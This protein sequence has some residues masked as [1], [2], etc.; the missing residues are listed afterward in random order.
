MKIFDKNKLDKIKDRHLRY[1]IVYYF[2]FILM[3]LLVLKLFQLTI[4]NGD[5]YRNKSDNNRLKD[6]KVTAPR[7][8]IY[9]RNG[10]LLAGVKSTPAVQILKDEFN[11]LDTEKRVNSIN[12]LIKYLSNDGSTWDS[13]DYFIGYNY[14]VY[15]SNTDY[16]TENKSPKEKILDII[17]EN[18][19]IGDILKLR[20]EKNSTSDFSY[21]IIKN[22]IRDLQFK[23]IYIP[24]DFFYVNSGDIKFSEGKDYDEYAKDKN[25]SKGIYSHITDL[26]KE[27]KSIIRKILEQ[28]LARKLIYDELKSKNLLGNIEM[29]PIADKNLYDYLVI[30]SQLNK[31]NSKV[32]LETSTEDDFYNM[33][34]KFTL[35]KLLKYVHIDK[36]T[37][38]K[39]IPA[40]ILI[41]KLKSK[42]ISL[43]IDYSV[44]SDENEKEIVDFSY[45]KDEDSNIDALNYLINLADENNVLREF[46]LSE[47]IAKIAQIVN[48]KENKILKISITKNKKSF[49]FEYIFE[50]ERRE[51][52]QRYNLEPTY[53]AAEL[54]S[55]LKK[56]YD[57]ENLDDYNSYN[58]LKILRM[59]ELQGDK[60]YLP[61]N[62]TYGISDTCI[63]NIKEHFV[64]NHGISVSMEPIRYYPNG[65]IGAHILGYIGK[66]S[67]KEEIEKYNSD[68]GYS[69]D[70]FIGKTGVEESQE[71]SLKGKDGF[72][73]VMVDNR[74]N[75][76]ETITENQ[77][78]PG[79]NVYLSLDLNLQKMAEESLK[80]TID[81]IR[82]HSEYESKWGKY[83]PAE[84]YSN[85]NSGAVVVLDVKTGKV[86]ALASYP[87]YDPNLF[88]T[89]ISNSDWISLS[90]EDDRDYLAPKPLYNNAIQSIS[91]PGST[92]KLVSSLAALEKGLD[93]NEQINCQGVIELGDTKFGCWIWNYHN[94]THGYEN[95][96]TALRDSCNYYFYALALG[97]NPNDNKATGVKIEIN[98]LVNTAT[99]LGL[100]NKTGIEINIPAESKGVV[101]DPDTKKSL[102]KVL[103]KQKLEEEIEKYIPNNKNKED[104]DFKGIVEKIVNWT[105]EPELPSRTEVIKRLNEMG[106]DAEKTLVGSKAT[107]ADIIKYD[108]INQAY[109]SNADSLN[110]VIGQGQNSYTTIQMARLMA[111]MSNGGYKVKTSLIDKILTYDNKDTTF[112]NNPE[113][114]KSKFNPVNLQHILDGMNLTSKSSENSKIYRNLPIEIGNKT[115]TA[116]KS[117]T[118]PVTGKLYDNYA[119][120]VAFAPYKNPEIA[121]ATVII[122]G[123][124]GVYCGPIIRDIVGQ[125]VEDS[126]NIKKDKENDNNSDTNFGF[127]GD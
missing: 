45:I 16:F 93:P 61:I 9:D 43:N 54:F 86:L 126:Q 3:G 117:G 98:D 68:K 95:L 97:K 26:I 64:N 81:S 111:M 76:T 22:V 96:R 40:E 121:I 39:T 63:S 75:R 94:Q 24:T 13:D 125:Y 80:K 25:L 34:K 112:D 100:G 50:K 120:T 52:A 109:W 127:I 59:M 17:M 57:I 58:Y 71:F 106:L 55:T 62:L 32:T 83:T 124:S 33:V 67:Q 48:T 18:N 77:A 85:A 78:K 107:L 73:R 116:Q 35:N 104:Y 31:Q 82:T 99:E 103:L 36:D 105:D 6:I 72:K 27:D 108:Y 51:I 91:Q 110:T 8:N 60:A 30:K 38:K 15:K 20:I 122:Q 115:G 118:N 5:N 46:V 21:Y 102:T 70:S 11:R 7:G 12:Q 88:V 66:I 114:E 84:T 90:P 10:N 89:G 23:G 42:N 65:E 44:I 53:K 29:L 69:V 47:E 41:N 113:N 49:K 14:F 101:P 28:P 74:G 92:F 2:L 87:S 123:G 4:I 19:L 56:Y 119:W 79:N 1:S 37:K